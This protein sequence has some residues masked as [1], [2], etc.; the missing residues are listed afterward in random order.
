MANNDK[1]MMEYEVK[2]LLGINENEIRKQID[3][4][5]HN[6]KKC[7]YCEK[8]HHKDY[9]INTMNYC[10]HCWAWLNYYDYDLITDKYRGISTSQE[11]DEIKKT[12]KRVYKVH[13]QAN[14]KNNECIFNKIKQLAENKTLHINLV[15]LLELNEKIEIKPTKINSKNKNLNIDYDKSYIMI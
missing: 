14:C 1:K 7:F 3:S 2:K 11:M 12:I 13:L 8:M 6:W 9:Y 15:N 10:V 5:N 4:L